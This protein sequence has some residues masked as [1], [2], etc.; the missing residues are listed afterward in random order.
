MEQAD[1]TMVLKQ[2]WNGITQ[3]IFQCTYFMWQL[4]V[5]YSGRKISI[6]IIINELLL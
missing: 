4:Q 2:S 1:E 6:Y 5:S 3:A